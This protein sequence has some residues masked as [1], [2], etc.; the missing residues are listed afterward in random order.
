MQ[1]RQTPLL[2]R[3]RQEPREQLHEQDLQRRQPA[4]FEIEVPD[5]G[6][7]V[8]RVHAVDGD[9][10]VLRVQEEAALEL[11]QPDLEVELVVH[12]VL[13]AVGAGEGEGAVEVGEV[14]LAEVVEAAGGADDARGGGAG[15]GGEEAEGEEDVGE[16]VD[17]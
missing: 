4:V 1:N 11:G 6:V 8:A 7:D 17:L 9:V 14:E 5:A 12:V 13:D 2:R 10:A 15:E 16:E 3:D